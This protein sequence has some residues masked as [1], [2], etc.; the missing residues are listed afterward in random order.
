MAILRNEQCPECRESGHDTT[1]NHLL[2]FDD[3]A[4]FCGHEN[5]HK[6]GRKLYIAPDGTD[7]VL[8]A[9]L[10]GNT[11]FTVEQF[12]ALAAEGRLDNSTVRAITLKGMK[13]QDAYTVM[14]EAEKELVRADWLLDAAYF[15]ALKTKNL[16]SRHIKGQIAKFY[17]VKVGTDAKGE[18][19]RHYYPRYEAGEWVGA[20]CR[21]LPKD[22]RYGSLGRLWGSGELFGQNTLS[23][24]LATGRRLDTLLIVGGECDAMAAQQMLLESQDGTSWAGKFFHVWSV[25]KGEKCLE[26]ILQNKEAIGKFKKIIVAFDDDEVGNALNKDVARLFRGKVQKLVYP[27]GCKDA[28]ACLMKGKAKE[29]VDAWFN[30][31]EVFGG[32]KLKRVSDISARAKVMPVMGLSWPWPDMNRLTFGI[33]P[34][35]LYVFGAGTGVGKTESTKEIVY[36]LMQEHDEQVGV[37][38][39]EEQPYTTVRSFAGKLINKRIEDPPTNDRKDP[40]YRELSDYKEEAANAAIDSLVDLDRLIVVD[41]G[42]SKDIDTVMAL[43]EELL[44]MGVSYIVVDNLTAIELKSGTNKVEAIDEAMKRMGTF[45]DEKPVTIFL[46]SHLTRPQQP[47]VPHEKGGEVFITD[48]RGAGSITFWANGVFGIERN[49]TAETEEEQRLTTY[50]CVKSRDNGVA[51]GKTVYATMNSRTGRLLQSS[52][53]SA[54]VL[55]APEEKPVSLEATVQTEEF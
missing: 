29:F 34:H 28:N 19:T 22:F 6:S 44:A 54:P 1:G 31:V 48:F 11:R 41:T 7:P 23:D 14:N 10:D 36:H 3:G 8:D 32:G 25:M 50:R 21:T 20:K 12:K 55:K 4:K 5:Y 40:G 53:H 26:E 46:L 47:R 43:I 39:L 33:R 42:G 35:T 18:V 45:K 49:T 16:I 17:D 13:N 37:I 38:Y 9:K 30:T 51:G 2:V 24:V 15:S 27:A 52:G